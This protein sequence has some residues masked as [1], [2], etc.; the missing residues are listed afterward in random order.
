MRRL[1]G[2][3]GAVAIVAS[4]MAAPAAARQPLADPVGRSLTQGDVYYASK[5]DTGRLA[6][7]DADLLARKDSKLVPILVKVDMDPVASY[8]GGIGRFAATSPTVTGRPLAE[9]GKAVS[10]YRS[11]LSA[12]VAG[13]RRL[14]QRVVPGLTPSRLS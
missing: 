12:Q 11:Y 13:V 5:S 3:F 6:Q 1:L 10:S 4:A 9:N 14:A 8:R 2:V 7:S